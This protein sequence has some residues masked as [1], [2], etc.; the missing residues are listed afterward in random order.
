[1]HHVHSA[2]GLLQPLLREL[3]N[4]ADV[5]SCLSALNV[6]QQLVESAATPIEEDAHRLI[7]TSQAAAALQPS[8]LAT[9]LAS[10]VMPQL[11]RLLQSSQVALRAGAL[12]IATALLKATLWAE[13]C[14]VGRV[15][16]NGDAVMA[17]A[18]E[19]LWEEE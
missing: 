10:L 9:V 16:S 18:G 1:M 19:G 7:H 12:P 13:D 5:L 11:L 17:D 2:T 3:E 4:T 15:D 6:V 8:S 14:R